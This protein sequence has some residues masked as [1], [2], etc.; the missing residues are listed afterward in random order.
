MLTVAI[1]FVPGTFPIPYCRALKPLTHRP[2]LVS[3]EEVSLEHSHANLFMDPVS[4]FLL[5]W[6][7][8]VVVTA[9]MAFE[10]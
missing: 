8:R 10:A 3:V 9:H 4:A 5:S 1:A 7:N 6:Q 2:D